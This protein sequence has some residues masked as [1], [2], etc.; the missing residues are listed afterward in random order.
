MRSG[1]IAHVRFDENG[2]PIE[3]W[4]DDHLRDVAKLAAEFAD[5]FGADWAHTAGIWHDLGKYNPEFQAYIRH[6][7]GYERENAH[8]ETAGRVDHSTAGASYAVEKLGVAGRIL[9]YLI[10][11]HHAGLPDWHQELGSGGALKKRLENKTHLQKATAVSIP[12]DILAAP[13]LQPPALA[14]QAENFALWVRMLF[15]ALVDADFLD[16]ERFMSEAKFNQRGQYQSLTHL[17]EVFNDH[18]NTLAINAKPSQVNEIRADI[19]RQCREAAEKPVGLFS[20]SVP[21]GGGKTLSS[22][23]F[24]L[25]HAVKQGM[26]RII[27]VIPYTSIIEQTAQVFRTIF[28]D[29]NVVEHHSNTDPDKAEK[30]NA[31]S[32]LATENWDAPIIVTTSVQYFES[33]F[34]ARTSRCRKLHNIANSVVVLDETQLLPPEHLKPILR[35]MRQLSAHYRVTQVLSTATQP[36]LK[37]QLDPF[38]RVEREGLDD[39]CEI[40][41]A[42]ET[43]YQQLE[44]VRLELPDD[45]QT[46]RSWEELA[47]ELEDYERVLVIVSRRQDARDL[48]AL[49]PKGT[50]HLSALMCAQHRSQVIDEIKRKLKTDESVRVVSTQLVE[51]GV[52]MDFPVVYRAMAGLDSIA[53]AAGRCNRE[54]LLSDKGKVVVFIPPKPSR[55]LLGKA[56]ESGV[57]MLAA[58]AGQTLESLPPQM[59]TQYFDQFYNKLNTLD[60]AGINELL[61]PDNQLGDC[62][63]RTA[64]LKFRMIE[65]GDTYT[66][67]VKFDEKAAELLATLESM[68][69]ERWLMRKLQRYTVTLYGY[70]FRPLL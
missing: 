13:N 60:K 54:G 44:R 28:G 32:R 56:A 10:A 48:H 30:E 61:M 12:A 41:S 11:G 9:A 42:S 67:F 39:V 22:M 1:F 26:Q 40:I 50:Y 69:P 20:L 52:D 38:G 55:G 45:F 6:K 29:E 36:A 70:Q 57:S 15:S 3:H 43:L 33:L 14:R 65:D 68:G 17:R 25:D 49:M 5:L 27:Y 62:Q 7:T 66:V 34:A 63:F 47:E 51:A 31:Q 23:A 19:L 16:T 2:E 18:M 21:T 37:T 58:L 24:A 8:I 64:A 59:F 46:S 4:L 53:Q 35:V